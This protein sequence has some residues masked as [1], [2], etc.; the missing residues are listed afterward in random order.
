[1][2]FPRFMLSQFLL[3]LLFFSALSLTGSATTV[4]ANLTLNF[5]TFFPTGW[6]IVYIS[7]QEKLIYP[8][9]LSVTLSFNAVTYALAYLAGSPFPPAQ[10]IM[11]DFILVTVISLLGAKGAVH[12]QSK[13]Q[14]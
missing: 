8:T 1:M 14:K 2:S 7:R 11:Y 9:V 5:I 12:V 4:M 13:N 3:F 6:L 10:T